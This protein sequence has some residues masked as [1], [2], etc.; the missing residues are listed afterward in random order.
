MALSVN[1]ST[2]SA[3][4]WRASGQV[5]RWDPPDQ[6]TGDAQRLPGRE[7]DAQVGTAGEQ[8]GHQFG[9][10][11]DD[12][13]A[14]VEQQQGPRAAQPY[15]QA[16]ESGARALLPD[17]EH[18]RD[19]VR[20]QVGAGDPAQLDQPHAVG[21][22]ADEAARHAQREARLADAAHTAAERDQALVTQQPAQFVDVAGAADE[23]VG[24]S[25]EVMRCHAFDRV[26]GAG[27]TASVHAITRSHKRFRVQQRRAL[28]FAHIERHLRAF[29]LFP[30]PRPPP[31]G[32]WCY[33]TPIVVS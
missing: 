24:F 16:V 9:A 10:A 3:S 23:T 8:F 12:L 31:A 15:A 17:P 2:A 6:L 21:E 4:G 19:L 32:T 30:D 28:I 1:S 11:L 27:V 14:V 20:D 29:D 7:Q 13:L 22:L 18:G 26:Y 33:K 5:E 25:R